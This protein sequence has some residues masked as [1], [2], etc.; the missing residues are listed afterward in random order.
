MKRNQDY[1]NAG[2]AALK[3]NW[4]RAILAAF[5][6]VFVSAVTNLMIWCVGLIFEY[7][8]LIL[9]QL[10]W[11][12]YPMAIFCIIDL[13]VLFVYVILPLTVAFINSFS[14]MYSG[15]ERN[16]L[17]YLKETTFKSKIRST[18]AILLMN[19]VVSVCS[20]ALLVPGIIASMSLFLTPY[21]IKDNPELKVVDTLRLSRKMMQGHKLQLFKLQLSFLGWIFLNLLTLGIGS[22]WLLPYMMTTM[23]AFYQ[24]VK[25]E[26]L[27]KEGLQESAS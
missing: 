27:K 21:L 16:P 6:M 10:G 25:A 20:L 13:L 26:Y 8:D 14:K 12:F 7:K 11:L 18:A 17:A 19:I 5:V 1:K 3:G 22:L 9:N 15:V 24:D 4:E 23:A 2:L